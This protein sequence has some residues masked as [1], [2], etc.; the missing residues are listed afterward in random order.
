MSTE[1]QTPQIRRL[2]A[3]NREQF[4]VRA[5][6]RGKGS[7]TC[8]NQVAHG[9]VHRAI[10]FSSGDYTAY[11]KSDPIFVIGSV[12][13][14]KIL[15][16]PAIERPG[17]PTR[18]KAIPRYLPLDIPYGVPLLDAQGGAVSPVSPEKQPPQIGHLAAENREQFGVRAGLIGKALPG[19]V[20]VGIRNG[21]GHPSKL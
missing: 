14:S 9:L 20:N 1:E 2:A 13:Y 8:A 21:H 3:D 6:E 12:T 16:I 18:H 11:V 10:F 17:G 19:G 4:R 7:R 15:G 5:R